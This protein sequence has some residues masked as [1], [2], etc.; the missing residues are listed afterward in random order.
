MQSCAP[1]A[2]AARARQGEVGLVLATAEAGIGKSRLVSEFVVGLNDALTLV[3]H[4]VAMSTGE[5]RG[6]SSPAP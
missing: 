4:G 6:P 3:W 1:A 5:M 2:A